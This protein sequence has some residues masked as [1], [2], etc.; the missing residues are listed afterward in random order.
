ML[1][2]LFA[3]GYTMMFF[4]I[5]SHGIAKHNKKLK[6]QLRAMSASA[7][8]AKSR[9]DLF[10]AAMEG[11]VDSSSRHFKAIY[12]LNTFVMRRPSQ[13]NEIAMA[14]LTALAE[15][16]PRE[17]EHEGLEPAIM[18]AARSTGDGITQLILNHSRVIRVL[19]RVMQVLHVG[20]KLTTALRRLQQDAIS[21]DEDLQVFY[22]SKDTFDKLGFA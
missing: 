15:F 11:H 22:D 21:R 16:E 6:H 1:Y 14:M 8:F 4:G 19:E 18:Q 13:H 9:H 5:R 7:H 20:V 17:E 2:L 10:L 3:L 12:G